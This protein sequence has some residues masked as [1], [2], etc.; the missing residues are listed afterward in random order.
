MEEGC[1]VGFG[2]V[3]DVLTA[4]YLTVEG[5]L[6]RAYGNGRIL[7]GGVGMRVCGNLTNLNVLC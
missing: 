7:N 1:G 2:I 3:L 4:A 6:F 5:Y